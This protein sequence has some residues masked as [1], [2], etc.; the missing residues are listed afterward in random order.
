M[1]SNTNKKSSPFMDEN[2]V[3][4]NSRITH[5]TNVGGTRRRQA[6]LQLPLPDLVERPTGPP[7]VEYWKLILEPRQNLGG[8][9]L[10][11]FVENN[12][13]YRSRTSFLDPVHCLEKKAKIPVLKI[14]NEKTEEEKQTYQ[15]GYNI[16]AKYEFKARLPKK[17][18]T[19]N[20]GSI[21]HSESRPATASEDNIPRQTEKRE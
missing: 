14:T 2:P 8:T 3:D 21:L 4:V 9:R 6:S 7:G 12:E 1:T 13:Q 18:E 17:K 10:A 20:H 5:L 11:T 15:K 16:F 19:A